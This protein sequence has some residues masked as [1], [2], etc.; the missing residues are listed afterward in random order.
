MGILTIF[1][2][3]IIAIIGYIT[4]KRFYNLLSVFCVLWST[5]V[6]IAFVSPYEMYPTSDKAYLL[7]LIGTVS[8]SIGYYIRKSRR[9]ILS[10]RFCSADEPCYIPNSKVIAFFA[11]FC[12][13][14]SIEK[15]VLIINLMRRGLIFANLRTM[16]GA[17]DPL[18]IHGNI[19]NLIKVF[20]YGPGVLLLTGLVL[21]NFFEKFMSK[22]VIFASVFSIIAN[23][24]I[25]GGRYLFVSIAVMAIYLILMYQRFNE[26]FNR[27][28]KVKK[29]IYAGV[30]LSIIGIS[31]ITSLR[32]N[33]YFEEKQISALSQY[34]LYFSGCMPLMTHWIEE[35]SARGLI[36]YGAVSVGGLL[37]IISLPLR[38]IGVNIGEW[39][40][41]VFTLIEGD[42]Q[43]FIYVTPTRAMNTFTSIF[44]YLYLDLREV[45]VILGMIFFGYYCNNAYTR[46][47][48]SRNLR[49]MLLF[50]L[51]IYNFSQCMI[52]WPFFKGPNLMAIFYVGLCVKR[53]RTQE[54]SGLSGGHRC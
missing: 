4:E 38:L 11:Y 22:G 34:V 41:N 10:K 9:V 53:V 52:R 31:V 20:V 42:F 12:A 54:Y 37:Q 48:Q 44:T 25:T 1:C 19:D 18:L 15:L 7:V 28:K 16:F 39:Y 36:T 3:L 17:S 45:G 29:K 14:Y 47:A 51:M 5:I 32:F 27:I 46:A 40:T 26:L 33:D 35:I 2:L 13:L 23:S 30:I 49:N 24:I 21:I 8:F 6:L 50:S 43:Q